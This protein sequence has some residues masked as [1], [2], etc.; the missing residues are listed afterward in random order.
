MEGKKLRIID[1]K[2]KDFLREVENGISY[3]LPVMLQ[4]RPGSTCAR[5]SQSSRAED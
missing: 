4:V 1:L 5:H 2:M 3:G